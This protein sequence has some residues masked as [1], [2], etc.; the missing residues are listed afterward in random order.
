[1]T[2]ALVVGVAVVAIL[3]LMVW[4]RFGRSRNVERS[5]GSYGRALDLLGETAKRREPPSGIRLH[6]PGEVAKPH[7]EAEVGEDGELVR[8]A[9]S[10]EHVQR[11]PSF[12][13]RTSREAGPSPVAPPPP[14]AQVLRPGELPLFGDDAV[15]LQSDRREGSPL[16]AAGGSDESLR[17]EEPTAVHEVVPAEVASSAAVGLSPRARSGTTRRSSPPHG[18]ARRRRV[19]VGAAAVGVLAVVVLAVELTSSP[20]GT[21]PARRATGTRPVVAKPSRSSSSAK[22]SS[23]TGSRPSSTGSSPPP[24]VTTPAPVATPAS[25]SSTVVTFDLPATSFA[26]SI[27]ASSRCWFGVQHP[28]AAPNGPYIYDET[29]APGASASYHAVGSVSVRLGAPSYVSVTVNGEALKLPPSN[30][31]PFDL[32]LL[33]E[34][35]TSSST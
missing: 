5:I 8:P 18:A 21:A 28:G 35:T 24:S 10:S 34:A 11:E 22:G 19:T 30:V 15:A 3:A 20:S 17:A 4:N 31:L 1:V 29:L 26:I 27:S 7:L 16:F 9:I 25:V 32:V 13:V 23:S 2:T 14:I 33:P 6:R 12:R